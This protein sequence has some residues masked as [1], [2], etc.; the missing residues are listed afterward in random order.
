MKFDTKPKP[1]ST[2]VTNYW[3]HYYVD[4]KMYVCSLCGNSGILDTTGSAFTSL[5]V[6][7][8]RKNLCVCPNGQIMRDI[9]HN[10]EQ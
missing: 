2:C 8:G 9:G 10:P 7:V 4:E 1:I 5:G 6:A 3:K